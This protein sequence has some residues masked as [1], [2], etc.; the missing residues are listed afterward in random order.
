MA[1]T[2]A[3]RRPLVPTSRISTIATNAGY[4]LRTPSTRNNWRVRVGPYQVEERSRKEGGQAFV[5]FSS[6]GSDLALK[7]ARPSDWSRRRMRREIA[8]QSELEHPNILPIVDQD[9][10]RGWYATRR[11]L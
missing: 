11:A 3:S 10:D 8:I 7:V 6:D 1:S 4:C 2:S 9:A 5:Y